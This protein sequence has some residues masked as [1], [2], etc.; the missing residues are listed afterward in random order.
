MDESYL[1]WLSGLPGFDSGKARH[2]AERFPSYEHLR[3]STREELTAVEGLTPPDVET[4][5]RLLRDPSGHDA[6]GQLFLCP[7]CGSFAGT[8]ARACPVCGVAF[9][10]STELDDTEKVE[11]VLTE[12]A[13]ARICVTCGA[14]M[15][16]DAAKCSV[17]GREYGADELAFLPGFGPSLEETLPFCDRCGAYLS[18]DQT[19]CSICGTSTSPAVPA[20]ASGSGKGVVKDF[21]SR[22]QRTRGFNLTSVLA[23]WCTRCVRSWKLFCQPFSSCNITSSTY[24]CRASTSR[25]GSRRAR[26][27]M[28]RSSAVCACRTV[29]CVTVCMRAR[30]AWSC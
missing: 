11:E 15:G 6:S 12:N 2:V 21:L 18:G 25:C 1:E 19:E 14:V 17:C 22:W 27:L 29:C 28:M 20:P 16:D 7:E 3:A 30:S 26:Q 13:P 4:L 8:K 23:A 9:E 24:C 5:F 10:D